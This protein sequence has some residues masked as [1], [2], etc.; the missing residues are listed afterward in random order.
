VAFPVQNRQFQPLLGTVPAGHPLQIAKVRVADEAGV[1]EGQD[2]SDRWKP[3]NRGKTEIGPEHLVGSA[4]PAQEWPPGGIEAE[5]IV[6]PELPLRIESDIAG[7][8]MAVERIYGV[9]KPDLL[10]LL[11]CSRLKVS[12]SLRT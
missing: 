12:S 6:P 7:D 4:C 5:E 11:S 3:G 8:A 2:D 9:K 1:G 10:T